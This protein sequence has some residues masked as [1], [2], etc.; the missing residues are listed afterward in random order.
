MRRTALRVAAGI[1]LAALALPVPA[2]AGPQEA[3]T[4][5]AAMSG[6][7]SEERFRVDLVGRRSGRCINA[8]VR[9]G[10]NVMLLGCDSGWGAQRWDL[11]RVPNQPDM[12]FVINSATGGCL[13]I[14]GYSADNG[15]SAMTFGCHKNHN[16]QWILRA[17]GD[18]FYEF[19]N[20]QSN[21]CLDA[22]LT[23]DWTDIY[24]WGCHGGG[25]QQ[26]LIR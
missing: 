9:D 2:T 21:R 24:Q 19:R 14:A 11:R 15:A 25:E 4:A 12:F 5:N 22:R 16:Q 1:S 13:E 3:R 18:G 17:R 26:W 23:A 6:S 7:A 20:R 10:G 8:P